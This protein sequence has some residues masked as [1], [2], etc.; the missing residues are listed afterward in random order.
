MN[1][2]R[3]LGIIPARAGSKGIKR[4][5]LVQ[6]N[7]KPMIQYTFEA[8]EKSR[9]LDRTV[10][11]SDDPEI[12]ELGKSFKIQIPFV[13]PE[14]LAT[15]TA[16]TIEVIKHTID[17]LEINEHYIPDAVVLL[18]PT[19]PL[20]DEID[21]DTSISMYVEENR[22]FGIESLIS[23]NKPSQHPAECFCIKNNQME[24][25]VNSEKKGRQTFPEYFFINGAIY[26]SSMRMLRDKNVFFDPLQRN[27]FYVMHPSHSIDID[28]TFELDIAEGLLKIKKVSKLRD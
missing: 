22:K 24:F 13:R 15:D 3:F 28:S 26:I 23:V 19:C 7:G 10:L 4:K 14:H 9:F 6:L 27:A 18:Q 21:I 20:R 17:Y 2:P 1:N 16:L 5:N 25:A 12:I 8:V 11:T